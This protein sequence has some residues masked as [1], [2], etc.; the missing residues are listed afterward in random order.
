MD[1]LTVAYL[2]LRRSMDRRGFGIVGA[3]FT[4]VI[5][6]LAVYALVTYG[7]SIVHRLSSG[8]TSIS[9][10]LNNPNNYE[11]K[12]VEVVGDFAY[13]AGDTGLVGNNFYLVGYR[14]T[15]GS[16]SLKIAVDMN[17]TEFDASVS[18]VGPIRVQG[19]FKSPDIILAQRLSTA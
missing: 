19:I 18:Q 10:I 5:A 3:I 13:V 6:G 2:T 4:M 14:I 16:H 1:L 7:P 17:T 12:D 9:D 11:G 15:D 8:G